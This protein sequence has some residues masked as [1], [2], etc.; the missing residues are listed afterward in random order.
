MK[1]LL[2][3]AL[4]F[5]GCAS[6]PQYQRCYNILIYDNEVKHVLKDEECRNFYWNKETKSIKR[7][8][9]NNK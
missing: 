3:L 2:L 1:K 7:E 5:S 9:V 8:K 6:H 4:L